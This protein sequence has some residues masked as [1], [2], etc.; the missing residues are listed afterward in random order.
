MSALLNPKRGVLGLNSG[1][2]L[3]IGSSLSLAKMSIAG[4]LAAA[5]PLK[6]TPKL[7]APAEVFL[8]GISLMGVPLL[9]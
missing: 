8:V 1:R 7:P 3:T 9:F 4:L 5:G 2:F 6:F